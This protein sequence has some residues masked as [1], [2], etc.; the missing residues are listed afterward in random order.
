MIPIYFP[1]TCIRDERAAALT[2]CFTRIV[3][4]QPIPARDFG[5]SSDHAERLTNGGRLDIR[6]PVADDAKKISGI[7][8][9]YRQWAEI[10]EGSALAFFKSQEG[11]TPFFDDVSAHHIRSE[12]QRK[13]TGKADAPESPDP[14]LLARIFLAVAQEFDLRESELAADLDAVSGMERELLKTLKG[15]AEF[16]EAVAGLSATTGT[17]DP[18]GRMAEERLAAWARLAAHAPA[19][20]GNPV[21]ITDSRRVWET[22]AD[23]LD[24]TGAVVTISRPDASPDVMDAGSFREALAAYLERLALSDETPPRPEALTEAVPDSPETLRIFRAAGLSP[25]QFLS[26]CA[27]TDL[28]GPEDRT[29]ETPNTVIVV[30]A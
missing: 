15:E 3:L 16:E 7:I 4:F 11:R 5:H 25:R 2:A 21:F 20:E 9:Q 10:H 30:L 6:V 14:L 27:G 19:A 29:A 18:G 26:R 13:A 1:F 17:N 23:I 22:V 24:L 12:V 28:P 8:A